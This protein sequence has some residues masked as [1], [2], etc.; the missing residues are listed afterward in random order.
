MAIHDWDDFRIASYTLKRTAPFEV[1]I[2]IRLVGVYSLSL[3]GVLYSDPWPVDLDSGKAGKGD[4][5]GKGRGK[6]GQIGWIGLAD[7]LFPCG[8]IYI[9]DNDDDDADDDDDGDGDG[10]D[11]DE[12]CIHAHM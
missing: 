9:Y 11:D 8:A 2:I 3:G 4:G 10:D 6:G 7:H 5:K 1:W 12:I